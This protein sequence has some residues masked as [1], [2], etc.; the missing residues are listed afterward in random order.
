MLQITSLTGQTLQL[1]PDIS[2]EFELNNL[3]LSESNE[4]PG[5]FSYPI[6][7]PLSPANKRFLGHDHLPETLSRF[8]PVRASVNGILLKE[9]TLSYKM[10]GLKASGFLKLDQG[11]VAKQI[12]G[13]YLWEV[14]NEKV[15]LF[16]PATDAG[17]TL[18]AK[19][20]VIRARMLEMARAE[21][22]RYPIVFFP[23]HNPAF[24]ME[25]LNTGRYTWEYNTQL[26]LFEDG[27]FKIDTK[28]LGRHN[29]PFIY[30]TYIFKRIAEHFNYTAAGSFLDDPQVR[31]WVLYN[32]QALASTCEILEGGHY[33]DLRYHVPYMSVSDFLR[34]FK[35]D[36]GLGIFFDS[37][38]RQVRFDLFRNIR[39]SSEKSIDLSPYLLAGIGT[40][41][42]SETGYTINSAIDDSDEEQKSDARISRKIK[43]G[44]KE[45]SCTISTLKMRSVSMR[46]SSGVALGLIPSCSQKGNLLSGH[47]RDQDQWYST[48]WE[49]KNRF[50]IR[51]LTYCGMREGATPNQ[52]YPF[53]TSSTRDYNQAQ[54]TE[55][56]LQPQFQQSVFNVLTLAFYNFL[57][58]T[59]RLKYE[60]L[61]PLARAKDLPMHRVYSVQ[62]ENRVITRFLL[63]K[64]NYAAPGRGGL[65]P[66][67]AYVHVLLPE[68]PVLGSRT[69]AFATDIYYLDI[70]MINIRERTFDRFEETIVDFAI[71][72]WADP[73]KTVSANTTNLVVNIKRV[74][75]ITGEINFTH[76]LPDAITMSGHEY[77]IP[78]MSFRLA[79]RGVSGGYIGE[80]SYYIELLESADYIVL[81]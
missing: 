3:L 56:S 36:F 54:V 71:R 16:N 55:W 42:P 32:T 20:A 7:F 60:F 44:D 11:E 66:A 41:T 79:M 4:M 33:A 67:K 5:S 1:D 52:T 72:A 21:P 62:N 49:H 43:D 25:K 50:G 81:R 28:T 73:D 14:M 51:L 38:R 39:L 15:Y 70:V 2:V 8:H 31:S 59:R 26:N 24:A 17:D 68:D 53:A 13:L 35:N 80:D 74:S 75:K 69:A 57:A 47:Y 48:G 30:L 61:L 63:E 6:S 27:Q 78:N 64:V 18:E 9:C 45:I 19:Q 12:K 34:A 22:G 46:F 23:V 65:L 37:T 58:H 76:E 29:V 40:E 77:I 10:E